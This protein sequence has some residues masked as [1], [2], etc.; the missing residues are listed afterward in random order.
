MCQHLS[1]D[2]ATQRRALDI[3]ELLVDLPV[4]ERET[5]LRLH[6][7]ADAE[8][9]AA[10]VRLLRADAA[11]PALLPTEPP[12][13]LSA[14]AEAPPPERI[15]P[16]RV[17][18]LL[19]RGGMGEVWLGERDDGLFE[20][21]VAIKFVRPGLITTEAA[22]WFD[23]ERKLLA[24]LNHPNIAR[25]YDAG[26]DTRG[27]PYFVMEYVDGES[28]DRFAASGELSRAARIRLFTKICRAVEHA[29]QRLVIHAD[30][31]PSNIVIDRNEQRVKLLDFGIA[32]RIEADTALA[33]PATHATIPLTRAYASPQRLAGA[34][35]SLADDVYSLGVI[36]TELIGATRQQAAIDADLQAVLAKACADEPARRYDSVTALRNDLE[37][38]EAGLPVSA[39]PLTQRYVVGKFVQRHRLSVAGAVLLIMGL[40]VT[41]IVTSALYVRAERARRDADQ[42]FAQLRQL[43]KFML[44]D[45]FDQLDGLPRSLSTRQDLAKVG[46]QYLSDLASDANAPLDVKVETLHG[47]LRLALVQAG[48]GM[49]NLGQL[50]AARANLKRADQLAAQLQASHVDK[51]QLAELRAKL[52]IRQSQIMSET[53]IDIPQ[54]ELAL[55]EARKQLDIVKVHESAAAPSADEIEWLMAIGNLR[56]WQ[57][58]YPQA[59]AFA[60]QSQQA[61]NALPGAQRDSRNM[62]L[63]LVRAIDQEAESAFYSGEQLE[64]EQVYRREL[65][66]ARDAMNAYPMNTQVLRAVSRA[67][68]AYGTTLVANHK[69]TEALPITAESVQFA[70]QLVAMSPNDADAVRVSSVARLGH[71]EALLEMKLYRQALEVFQVDAQWRRARWQQDLT[72]T[73]AGRDYAVSQF[74][75]GDVYREL[76]QQQHACG[77]YQAGLGVFES[78]EKSGKLTQFD[79]GYSLRMAKQNSK[80]LGC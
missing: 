32:R 64:A 56:A 16:Y 50:E 29:H 23:G 8:L 60:Q 61:I 45:L 63:S 13:Q 40:I 17:T 15:G 66:T 38:F 52:L 72:N 65:Q 54:A 14:V 73:S 5:Q 2:H 76:K 22:S 36:L 59:I 57:G 62:R 18:Q 43:S 47:L 27:L 55:A 69:G 42:R 67:A 80:A 3:F 31:K 19:G 20:Q 11:A 78:L 53:D 70:T 71:G 28:I 41:S 24:R 26:V 21:A 77:A 37:R 4:I 44:F 9:Q 68:W 25:I 74:T 75:I 39:Q 51:T 35:P 6:C 33:S 48:Q 46:Q 10:V 79:R 49:G 58:R 34:P 7:L 12:S 1:M 30:L